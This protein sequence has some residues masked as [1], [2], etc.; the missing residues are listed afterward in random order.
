MNY[1]ALGAT[2]NLASRLEG[3]NKSYGTRVLVSSAVRERTG[4]AFLFRSV[5]RIRPKG[6]AEAVTISELRS[7]GETAGVS[8]RN[9]CHRWEEAYAAIERGDREE[10]VAKLRAF[11]ADYPGDGVAQYH[12][13]Q[14]R[15]A[16]VQESA[17]E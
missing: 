3:L 4:R 6:F 9:F 1:T 7:E 17:R 13:R 11:L 5:D 15:V 2:I 12:A 16:S 8:E 14:F 10:V